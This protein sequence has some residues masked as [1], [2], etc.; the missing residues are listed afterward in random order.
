MFFDED[1][2]RTASELVAGVLLR[3]ASASRGEKA[4]VRCQRQDEPRGGERY[5]LTERCVTTMAKMRTVLSPLTLSPVK[6]CRSHGARVNPSA[7]ASLNSW[8]PQSQPCLFHVSLY[9]VRTKILQEDWC[10]TKRRDG[11][12]EFNPRQTW[13]CEKRRQNRVLGSTYPSV[14]CGPAAAREGGLAWLSKGAKAGSACTFPQLLFL[15]FFILPSP[16]SIGCRPGLMRWR[17]DKRCEICAEMRGMPVKNS[18][19]IADIKPLAK[20]PSS[21][22]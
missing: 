15:P 18:N 4:K 14:S 13:E 5:H 22:A 17:C 3:S 9:T 12:G 2:V 8:R 16:S 10:F 1:S 19:P 21:F 7:A 20:K 6:V 11:E